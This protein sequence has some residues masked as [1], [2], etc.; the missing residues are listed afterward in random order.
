[1]RRVG[2]PAFWRASTDLALVTFCSMATNGF[3]SNCGQKANGGAQQDI[4]CGCFQVVSFVVIGNCFFLVLKD[5]KIN[6]CT[7]D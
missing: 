3:V 4:A 1:M 6:Q 5:I 2:W 7:K